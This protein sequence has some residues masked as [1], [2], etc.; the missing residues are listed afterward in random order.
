MVSQR[1]YCKMLLHAVKYPHCTV[2][3]VLLAEKSKVKET[4]SL[5]LVDCVPLFHQGNGLTPMMEVALVQMDAYSKEKGL[6]LSGYY[7]ANANFKDSSPDFFANKIVEKLHENC[8]DAVLIMIDNKKLT[9][10]CTDI[11]LQLYHLG[12]GKLKQKDNSSILLEKKEMT[13]ATCRS[14]L[15]AKCYR[16]LVDFDGHLDDDTLSWENNLLNAEIVSASA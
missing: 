10:E 14:L 13:L 9:L 15:S 8:N 4:K 7:Q 6:L 5:L 1:A 2:N 11:A 16:T 3:G 12:D